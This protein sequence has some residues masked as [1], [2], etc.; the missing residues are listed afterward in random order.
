MTSNGGDNN[1]DRPWE[2][3][4]NNYIY[5]LKQYVEKKTTNI[6]DKGKHYLITRRLGTS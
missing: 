6:E 3:F 4:K 1:V 5:L 2:F